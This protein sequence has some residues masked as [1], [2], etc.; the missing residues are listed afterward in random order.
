MAIPKSGH[1]RMLLTAGSRMCSPMWAS[2]RRW[3]PSNC[4]IP[5]NL[6]PGIPQ[7]SAMRGTA[8]NIFLTPTR[9]SLWNVMDLGLQ[10]SATDVFR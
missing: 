5:S 10:S 7:F 1:G 4:D 6:R 9:S 8:Q 3:L 2:G